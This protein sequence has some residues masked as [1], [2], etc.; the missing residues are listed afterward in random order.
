MTSTGN[1]SK[2]SFNSF[3]VNSNFKLFAQ[4]ASTLL[5]QIQEIHSLGKY[6]TIGHDTFLYKF[7]LISTQNKPKLVHRVSKISS[8]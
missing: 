2:K 4:F 1:Y 3:K 5:L 8:H 6:L 7:D